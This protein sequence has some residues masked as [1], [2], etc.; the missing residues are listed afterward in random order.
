MDLPA[1]LPELRPELKLLSESQNR[2]GE[3]VW[4][5]ADPVRHRYF[6]ISQAFFELL[7]H[8]PADS[9]ENLLASVN[10][11]TAAGRSKLM[12]LYEF[13]QTNQLLVQKYPLR[14]RSLLQRIAGLIFIRIPLWSPQKLLDRL[15]TLTRVIRLQQFLIALVLTA[16]VGLILLLRQWDQFISGFTYLY[17]GSGWLI[18][19]LGII[20]CKFA[21]ELGHGVIARRY[22]CHVNTA[23]V[24]FMF[25]YPLFFVDIT[26][27]WIV[28]DH[29]KRALISSGGLLAEGFVTAIAIWMWLLL[30]DGP[31]QTLAQFIITIGLLTTVLINLNPFMRFDG[32]F[33]LA[34]LLN[35]HN[36]QERSFDF[37]KWFIRKYILGWQEN[38][39]LETS[40]PMRGFYVIFAYLTWV[41]RFLIYCGIAWLAYQFFIKPLAIVIMGG[42]VWMLML[43]PILREMEFYRRHSAQFK[44]K[45]IRWLWLGVCIVVAFYIIVPLPHRISLPAVLQSDTQFEL[46]N[47]QAAR[48]DS[49]G[50]SEG[51]QVGAGEL[52]VE[53]ADDN[54][55]QQLSLEK[56]RLRSAELELTYLIDSRSD[57]SQIR[58]LDQ[59]RL[60]HA[61]RIRNLESATERLHLRAPVTGTL[62]DVPYSL[63]PAVWLPES[64]PLGFVIDEQSVQLI[65]W[66]NESGWQQIT[67]GSKGVFFP[68]N[69]I[70]GKLSAEV[71]SI[72]SLPA[73]EMMTPYQMSVYGGS[74]P[75]MQQGDGRFAIAQTH[76]RVQMKVDVVDPGEF[77]QA[78]RGTVRLWSDPYSL[79][80]YWLDRLLALLI[81]ETGF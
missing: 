23:G 66:V 44:R 65:A 14:D 6:H 9:C 26:D 32:Y 54:L 75:V 31:L 41:W 30:P 80:G 12:E 47:V 27:G 79:G 24:A 78:L 13:L 46:L 71:D 34:D 42:A 67:K 39:P 69:S 40:R 38:P 8:W 76:Y 74:I 70:W 50:L 2:N 61:S 37:G 51:R 15:V 7:V 68:E 33:I 73:D 19:I 62:R 22:G 43:A 21:H 49:H 56:L 11:N 35:I 55:L 45:P 16:V 72:E 77:T 64:T 59:K 48:L 52:L 28:T 29:R 53:L 18:L 5:I 1:N 60:N 25:G 36:L 4:L 57:L 17:S 3:T 63:A 10:Q 81:R 20:L 58:V